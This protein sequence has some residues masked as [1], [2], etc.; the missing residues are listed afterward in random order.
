M[1]DN[2]RRVSRQAIAY[3]TADAMVLGI[4]I[5]LLPIYTRVLTPDEYGVLALLL[6]FEA[7]LKPTLRCGLDSAYLRLYFDHA[8]EQD[9]PALAKTV[10]VFVLALNGVILAGIWLASSWLTRSLLGGLDYRVALVLVAVNTT[11]SNLVFLPLCQFRAQERSMLVGSLSFLRSFATVVVRLV[12]VVGFRQGVFGLVLA[13]VIVTG[14]F[15][16]GL[17]PALRRMT[18]G[19]FS[20]AALQDLLQY[21]FPQVP[22]GLLGQVMAQAD[23]YVLGLHLSLHDVGVYSI[24]N[25]LASVLKLYPVALETAWMPFAFSSLKRRD[26]PEVFARMASYAFALLC[27]A[28]LAVTLFAGPVTRLVLPPSY[29]QSTVVVP[30][31]VLGI[32]IQVIAWFLA[33]SINVAKRTSRHPMAAAAGAAASV[34]GCLVLIPRFGLMGAAYGVGCGQLALTLTTAWFAQRYYPIPYEKTRLIKAGAAAL[35]LAALG[36]AAR[37]ESAWTNLGMAALLSAAYPAVLL[38]VRFLQPW[39]SAALR[40]FLMTRVG[41]A[42]ATSPKPGVG[43]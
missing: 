25:T 13:D 24:G 40:H 22:Q 36:T 6:V 18:D 23:R 42:E 10:L 39:E 21:G 5:V 31:L 14:V 8:H 26:A 2:L 11:L 19:R 27:L 43:P 16:V 30:V 34:M 20:R 33:T 1:F 29:F 3:G 17:G 41:S 38:T 35:A 7:V 15:V 37:T 4:N 9:R 28:A 32:T 12:L